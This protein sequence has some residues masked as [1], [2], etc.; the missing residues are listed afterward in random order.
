MFVWIDIIHHTCKWHSGGGGGRGVLL[1][2]KKKKRV[3]QGG[4]PL[5]TTAQ[6]L[7][8]LVQVII[9]GKN[10]PT[11]KTNQHKKQTNKQT[12]PTTTTTTTLE[13]TG[14]CCIST[15][16]SHTTVKVFND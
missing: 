13:S 11:Q 2:K 8:V 15:Y 7:S 1:K 14:K 5:H 6:Q 16:S 4:C 3:F 10:K 9:K 12:T